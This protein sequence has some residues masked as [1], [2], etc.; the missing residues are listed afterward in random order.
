MP[1]AVGTAARTLIHAIGQFFTNRDP[2]AHGNF[3]FG[4]L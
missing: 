1:G 3:T 4:Y 2:R